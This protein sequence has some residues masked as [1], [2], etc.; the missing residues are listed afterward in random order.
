MAVPL[1]YVELILESTSPAALELREG[2]S[3]PGLG[4]VHGTL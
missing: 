4:V 1:L 2:C 3:S